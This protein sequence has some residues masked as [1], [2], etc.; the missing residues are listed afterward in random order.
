MRPQLALKR[1]V[2]AEKKCR[3]VEKALGDYG[4]RDRI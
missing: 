4:G 2:A 3:V 1:V